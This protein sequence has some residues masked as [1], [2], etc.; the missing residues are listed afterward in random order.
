MINNYKQLTGKYIIASKKRTLLTIIG[1]I[2]SVALISSIGLFLK[3]MQEAMIEEAIYDY[4]SYH[5]AFRADN[6]MIRKI[7]NNPKVSKNGLF[8]R[9]EDIK[10]SEKLTVTELIATD[11]AL[12]LLP[13]RIKEGRLPESGNEV[14]IEKWV[15]RNIVGNGIKVGDKI[16]INNREYLLTGILEDNIE[17]QIENNGILLLKGNNIDMENAILLVQ[18]SEKTNLNRALNELRELGGGK[19]VGE[20]RHLITYQGGE[21]SGIEG[22]VRVVAVIISIVVISTIAV[23]YN[24][25]HISVVERI[26]QFGLLRAI[27]TTPRQI[28]IIVLREA[29]ILALIGVPTG[30]L[31]G[32]IAIYGINFAFNIIGGDSI[33]VMSPSISPTILGISAA[34]GILSVY[35]SAL[36]PAFFA[37]RISPLVAISSRTSITKE[38]IK[39]RKSLVTRILFGFEGALAA[40]NMKRNKKRYRVTV[41]SISISVLLFVTFKSFMDLS[42]RVSDDLN[43]SYNVH[44]SVVRDYTALEENVVIDDET[45]ENIK[46]L[47]SVKTVF[48]VYDAYSFYSVIDKDSEIKE[49]QDINGI[50]ND[51]NFDGRDMTLINSSVVIYDR[52]SLDA[53][54]EYIKSGNIDIEKLNSE[55]G[56]I[57]IEKS[58]IY[59]EKTDN[60][61][62]GPAADVKVGDEIYLQ[63]NDW[64]DDNADFGSGKV[65]KVKVM[66][67]LKS[68][69][70]SFRGS[71]SGLKIITTEE[72]AKKLTGIEDIKPVNLNIIITEP[73][74]EK[75]A[76]A[77]LENAI[78]SNPSLMLVNRIDSNRNEKSSKLM[79]QILIYGFVIVVSL[80]GSVNII[81]TLTTNI[82]LR[83]REFASLKCIGLTQKGL[84][85]MIVLE[86][87]M[88][89]IA[90]TIYGSIVGCVLSYVLYSGIGSVRET[91]WRIPWDAIAIA[92]VCSLIIGYLSILSPLSRIKKDNLIEAVRNEY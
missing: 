33:K 54:K 11:K 39:R 81:N 6:D 5:L 85:K 42:F 8:S 74:K 89:G 60:M 3:G 43:G 69:P 23:I 87:F 67:I 56:I 70:F 37:G 2:L 63:Y 62:Y 40:K 55:N 28:R 90:G 82:I 4:G 22:L 53:S 88:Y 26:K 31:C 35:A 10:V 61:Y 66:A 57:I 24:A 38:K 47:E 18:I 9:G 78:A 48:K 49:I 84:K 59:N 86:G 20:N 36:M 65:N 17:N 16:S 32:V 71:Q 75:T 83:R 58:K 13:Y 46:S 73:E 45:V 30:L 19:I 92:T 1:I 80:I 29:T 25:F 91:I 12:E 77:E 27:G 14:A 21:F 7:T 51:I 64:T 44:F 79:I 52:D 34:I 15:L 68:D 41:F 72:V 50:Y 76:L